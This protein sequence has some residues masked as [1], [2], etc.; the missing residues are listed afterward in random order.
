MGSINDLGEGVIRSVKV[1]P[2]NRAM[3]GLKSDGNPN[4]IATG[5]YTTVLGSKYSFSAIKNP[6][7]V[8]GNWKIN[9]VTLGEFNLKTIDNYVDGNEATMAGIVTEVISGNFQV[10]WIVYI[11]VKDNGE[12][13]NSAPD[14]SSFNLIYYPDWFNFYPSVDAFLAVTNSQTMATNSLFGSFVD[15]EGQIQVR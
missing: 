12:G 10:N 2:T 13:K 6:G 4:Q 8:N 1:L 5:N 3:K 9:S 15:R 14:Q 11:K 7:G